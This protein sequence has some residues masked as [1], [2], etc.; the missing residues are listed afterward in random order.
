MKRELVEKDNQ[1][2]SVRR[3]CEILAFNRS[4]LYYKRTGPSEEDQKI[5]EEMDRIYLDFP[6]YGSRRMSRALKRRDYDVGRRKARHLMRILGVEA[7][8]PRKRLKGIRF[9]PI[10]FGM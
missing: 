3:Q 6:Y 9:I 2:L 4:S 5:L 10:F 8:Y 1:E 7:I